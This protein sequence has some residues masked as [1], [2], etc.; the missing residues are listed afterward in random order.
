MDTPG[1]IHELD[2][3]K[4][5]QDAL[6]QAEHL[7]KHELLAY[8]HLPKMEDHQ[9]RG[10]RNAVA[11]TDAQAWDRDY[12]SALSL[13]VMLGSR[14]GPEFNAGMWLDDM[15][16]ELLDRGANPFNGLR[17][18]IRE[19][20]DGT[21]HAPAGNRRG[22][23]D[24]ILRRANIVP[25]DARF[26]ATLRSPYL[27][28]LTM[29]NLMPKFMEACAAH[30]DFPDAV[31]T[32]S[33]LNSRHFNNRLLN[34]KE[35][36]APVTTAAALAL[37]GGSY[38]R[39]RAD[40]DHEI[41]HSLAELM[42]AGLDITAPASDGS[43]LTQHA[44]NPGIAKT[45]I[46]A[47]APLTDIQPDA[48]GLEPQN[49][50]LWW[51]LN[52]GNDPGELRKMF[53]ATL[54]QLPPVHT[55]TILHLMNRPKL[56]SLV[57]R[58]L[59]QKGAR[60][61]HLQDSHPWTVPFL[62]AIMSRNL[63]LIADVLPK[64]QDRFLGPLDRI[65]LSVPAT[66]ERLPM[67]EW[68]LGTR[69]T[70]ELLDSKNR[71][72]PNRM[73][74]KNLDRLDHMADRFPP[75]Q[76][77]PS[78]RDFRVFLAQARVL[79]NLDSPNQIFRA[80][81]RMAIRNATATPGQLLGSP[82]ERRDAISRHAAYPKPAGTFK[83]ENICAMSVPEN[84]NE[85]QTR[86]YA[87]ILTRTS[88]RR[89]QTFAKTWADGL[90][91]NRQQI[92][93]DLSDSGGRNLRTHIYSLVHAYSA[94]PSLEARDAI[95]IIHIASVAPAIIGRHANI[96]GGNGRWAQFLTHT[97]KLAQRACREQPNAMQINTGHVTGLIPPDTMWDRQA[98]FTMEWKEDPEA[99]QETVHA[100]AQLRD[101][102][103]KMAI[104]QQHRKKNGAENREDRSAL[105]PRE[106]ATDG[107]SPGYR[108][109]TG[110]NR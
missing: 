98:D 13:I 14:P 60:K 41:P 44:Q 86:K 3:P 61:Q 12:G 8:K 89:Q 53:N 106:S 66:L 43:S 10:L 26:G 7:F 110:T 38:G 87:D 90:H 107:N 23:I 94:L 97:A 22:R 101:G 6:E 65:W 11:R 88:L 17:E 9:L 24:E 109:R 27:L 15:A 75:D 58:R 92:L 67:F 16:C 1:N 78:D 96:T 5:L 57:N 81:G 59:T 36:A 72:T 108:N 29:G 70:Q 91:G 19:L 49:P 47:G 74:Q 82:A 84:L 28:A 30:R 39:T 63:D 51:I 80:S 45:L 25:H 18:G 102:L 40:F 2:A 68:N 99:M 52:W 62:A 48:P 54:A 4:G 32:L 31:S 46:E 34:I 42:N 64:L 20:N 21:Q 104:N 50:E 76:P 71:N 37:N 73:A 55:Q 105:Q 85:A 79:R 35:I 100:Y 103:L 93:K 33:L 69:R 56:F 95:N 83:R 77:P